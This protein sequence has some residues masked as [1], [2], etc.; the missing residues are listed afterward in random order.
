MFPIIAARAAALEAPHAETKPSRPHAVLRRCRLRALALACAC[1]L[2]ALPPLPAGANSGG[3]VG[4]D[5]FGNPA[6][7]G[8][9]TGSG[10]HVIIDGG[11]DGSVY[12]G[13]TDAKDVNA[14]TNTVIMTGGTVAGDVIGGYAANGG[15]VRN[16]TVII[17]GGTVR[18][19][20]FG[21]KIDSTKLDKITVILSGSPD[22]SRCEIHGHYSDNGANVSDTF[23]IVRT[24]GLTAKQLSGFS[25]LIFQL[26]AT[27]R[28]DQPAL[29]LTDSW[30]ALFGVE[31]SLAMRGMSGAGRA[32]GVG[33]KV[34]ILY[35]GNGLITASLTITTPN[36]ANVQRG[37]SVTH[38]LVIQT[39]ATSIYAQVTSAR[40]NPQTK[41]LSEGHVSGTTLALQGADLAAGKGMEAAGR[42]VRASLAGGGKG[43]AAFGALSGGWS[44][45]NTGSHIDV[46]GFSLL[47]G[48]AWGA[49]S[50][51]G[52]FTTGLFFEYGSAASGTYNSFSNAASVS[53][54]GSS[55]YMGAGLLARMDFT[56][57][58]PGNFYAEASGR[59]GALNNSYRNDDLRDGDG[60]RAEF[61]TSTPYISLHAGLGYIWN[62]TDALSLD[63]SAKYFWTWQDSTDP[64]LSTGETLHFDAVNSHRLRLGGR[65]T[66]A[67]NEHVSPYVGAAWEHEF[68]GTA[69]ATTLGYTL[70]APSLKGDTGIGELGLSWTPSATTPLT[71][72]LSV[73]GYTGIRQ[74]YTGSLMAKWEF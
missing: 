46:S 37:V 14:D 40:F 33:D 3:E 52:Q 6:Y 58:G 73:Q 32:L 23:L 55:W 64:D 69:R 5:D 19:N 7:I 62:L 68:D 54:D 60:R 44:R 38:D 56:D 42:A 66:Y 27:F 9:T 15:D 53:G 30:T 28:V 10:G 48:L 17:S 43:V 31:F 70:D 45:Y 57:C 35:N 24:S 41:A 18:G 22:L 26:P 47:T 13:Y 16:S 36:L 50:V 74:G 20:V 2:T 12:G 25:Q 61:N 4:K 63:L 11:F 34:V 65:L 72:D 51:L 1:A 71:V 49:D 67:V 59:A 21:G 29:T 8:S 39:D